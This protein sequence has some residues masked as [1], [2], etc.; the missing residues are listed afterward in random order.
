MLPCDAISDKWQLLPSTVLLT[1]KKASTTLSVATLA[2]LSV[3]GKHIH[4]GNT[5]NIL[6]YL[7]TGELFRAQMD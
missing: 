2:S 6:V 3:L 4:T 1:F 7:R 5:A